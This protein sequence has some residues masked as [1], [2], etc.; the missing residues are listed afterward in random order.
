MRPTGPLIPAPPQIRRG[1][2][3]WTIIWL[4]LELLGVRLRFRL[5]F[6][7]WYYGIVV[8]VWCRTWFWTMLGRGPRRR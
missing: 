2:P 5:T 7:P 4:R 3:L 6:W 1:L 8:R